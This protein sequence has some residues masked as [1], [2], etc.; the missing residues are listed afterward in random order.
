MSEVIY[1][2]TPEDYLAKGRFQP[3][4]TSVLYRRQFWPGL[5]VISA[6]GLAVFFTQRKPNRPWDSKDTMF[7]GVFLGAAFFLFV[8]TYR[9]R[10]RIDAAVKK[11]LLRRFATAKTFAERRLQ[12]TPEGVSSS[13]EYG[14]ETYPWKVIEQIAETK[15]H[16][17]LLGRAEAIILPR[18]AFTSEHEFDEFVETAKQYQANAQK[19]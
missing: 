6:L 16:A 18:R 13:S 12:I 5:L 7:L 19:S 17:F 2:L 3:K 1:T 4:G 15:T 10:Y 14:S 11:R 9:L 8:L